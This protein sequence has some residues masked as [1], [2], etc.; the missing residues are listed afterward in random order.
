MPLEGAWPLLLAQ[1]GT[2]CVLSL[3]VIVLAPQAE[4]G[5]EDH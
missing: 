2:G 4:A 1:V 5:V 3:E